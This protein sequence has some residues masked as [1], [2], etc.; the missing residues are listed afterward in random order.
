MLH[1]E[2][3]RENTDDTLEIAFEYAVKNNIRDIVVA[4]TWGDTAEKIAARYNVK[5]FNVVVVT[6]NTGF[7]E[8]G[9]QDFPF[10]LKQELTNKGVRV[11]TGTMVLRS[12][13]TA[14]REQTGY[15][16]QILVANT[17]RMFCQGV[18]VCVEIVA[19]AADAGL[20]P[21]SDVVA[22]AGTGRGADTACLIRANS[23]NNFFK[24]KIREIIV[25][26]KE[27]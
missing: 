18:K 4:S 2:A 25:K 17:L 15:S 12:L 6:H 23:S 21:F 13:G 16:E 1:E 3:G 26:P 22:I 10:G 24:I 8:E 19:M 20:I 27:F 11:H 7:G 5:D 14:I 9:K